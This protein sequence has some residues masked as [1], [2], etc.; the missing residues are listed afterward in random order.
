MIKLNENWDS[1]NAKIL[2]NTLNEI[3]NKMQEKYF[4]I[5]DAKPDNN[6]GKNGEIYIDQ[7]NN[8]LYVKSY[9]NYLYFIS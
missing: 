1:E 3:Y 4:K 5:V 9:K 8:K 2:N 6:T 7:I